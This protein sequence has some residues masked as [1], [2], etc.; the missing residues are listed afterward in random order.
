MTSRE[1][2]SAWRDRAEV[3]RRY[4]AAEPATALEAAAAELEAALHADAA[5]LLTLQEA[6]LEG[7]YSVDHLG[8]LLRDHPALNAG[9]PGRPRIRRA[10]LPTKPGHTP[11]DTKRFASHLS[12]PS[13]DAIARSA[14]RSRGGG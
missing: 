10:D 9:S 13:I 7:G 1:L 6:A 12:T 5:E 11:S 2:P 3:L 14:I 4:G 8:R